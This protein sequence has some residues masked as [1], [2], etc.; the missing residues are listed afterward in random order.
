MKKV[1]LSLLALALLG[2]SAF[3]DDA[4]APAA[5]VVT[6]GDWG[7]QLINIANSDASTFFVQQGASWGNNPRIVGLNITAHNANAGFS[8]TP[9]AD[10]GG[11]GLTDQNKAWINPMDG[12]TVE[13]GINMETDT[14]RGTADFGSWDWY[15]P[16]NQIGD[17]VTFF[18]IGEE[19]NNFQSDIMYNKDG[20]GA[21]VLFDQGSGGNSAAGAV[22]SSI[23][24]GIQAGA[25]YTIA[26]IGVIKAQILGG[27]T[28]TTALYTG[29]AGDGKT[30]ESIQ[31][32][33]NLSAVQNLYEEVGV[34]VPVQA[35]DAGYVFQ[36][37]DYLT[38]TA[39]KAKIHLLVL[40]NDYN[41]DNAGSSGFGYIFGLG[42]DYDAGDGI[43][44][45]G[46]IRYANALLED[47]GASS[48]DPAQTSFLINV[49]K[50]FS[51]GLIGIGFQ[52]VT[53]KF[54]YS[55][56]TSGLDATIG[57]WAIPIELSEWF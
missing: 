19:D 7:R 50:N 20:I 33:F 3:A 49:T 46:D 34:Q 5:P 36:I 1:A 4:A 15:R 54:G 42:V 40:A 29:N 30:I 28:D 21:W 44:V 41:G 17:S 2:V 9:E 22:G 31:A 53:G 27:K 16:N 11:F 26:S 13:T 12:W 51:N 56:G 10:G 24:D 6:I 52:Y 18:R 14:W 23:G 55:T 57:H 8:I 32:A 38:Y 47:N 35:T 25:A 37:S 48:G 45:G 43:G 39:D